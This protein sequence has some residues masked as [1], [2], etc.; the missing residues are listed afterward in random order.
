MPQK[1]ARNT[2]MDSSTRIPLLRWCEAEP[3]HFV[4]QNSRVR[5]LLNQR[6]ASQCE[7][8]PNAQITNSS[9]LSAAN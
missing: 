8:S 3:E 7:L 5:M 1:N 6:S 2:E 9:E 4:T